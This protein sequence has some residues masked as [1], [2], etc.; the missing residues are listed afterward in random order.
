MGNRKRLGNI[1]IVAGILIIAIPIIGKMVINWEQKKLMENFYL[2]L[3]NNDVT[4]AEDLN[5]SLEESFLWGSSDENQDEIVEN[6]G[7][8]EEN[9]EKKIVKRL[10]K[11]IGVIEIQKIDVK[12]PIAEGVDLETLKFT[13]GHMPETSGLG[14]IGNTV[15]AGHRSNTFGAFFNRLDE[16]ETG[17]EITIKKSD[18]TVISYEV[19]EKLL[20]DPDDLSVL[21]GSDTFRVV[22]LITCDPVI[23][24]N[25]RLIVHGVVKE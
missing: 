8:I 12:L 1:L 2:E 10:P 25:K 6:T 7:L 4:Q 14:E 5:A 15:L 22:T 18:G 9:L 11:A 13:V 19:Y 24:P 20:V 23:N 16:V 21:K 3:E 17:D